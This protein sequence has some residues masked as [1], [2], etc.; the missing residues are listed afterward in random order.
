[1]ALLL[2]QLIKKDDSDS[3]FCKF[4]VWT[5]RCPV[6]IHQLIKK[7]DLEDFCKSVA[8]TIRCPMDNIDKIKAHQFM[9]DHQQAY[10]E[11]LANYREAG[12]WACS[13]C[14]PPF[15]DRHNRNRH[16]R[17]V[18]CIVSLLTYFVYYIV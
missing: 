18:N 4:V 3:D 10:K 16:R 1:M 11:E 2:H 17:R 15:K 6:D 7:E 9:V 8:W 12:Q 5:N 14:G 13:L